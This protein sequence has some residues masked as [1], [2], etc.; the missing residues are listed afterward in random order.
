MNEF[1]LIDFS[2]IQIKA[3]K[4]KGKT[5]QLNAKSIGKNRDGNKMVN[6]LIKF[7]HLQVRL[8]WRKLIIFSQEKSSI[9]QTI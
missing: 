7:L 6:H 1:N 4:I 9:D 5:K 8:I 3:A 2:F